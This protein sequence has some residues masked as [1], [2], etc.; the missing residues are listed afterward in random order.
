M[1]KCLSR[2]FATVICAGVMLST[3]LS[4]AA[5]SYTI[6]PDYP[7]HGNKCGTVVIK[8][9][10]DREITVTITQFTQDGDYVYYN[11][12]IPACGENTGLDDYHF[13]LEGKDDVSY[14]ISL[15]VAKFK[16]SSTYQTIA[17]EFNIPDTDNFVEEVVNGYITTFVITGNEEQEEP[18]MVIDT[19]PVTDENNN[20]CNLATVVYP[21]SEI[22]LGDLTYDE[23]VNIYDVIELAKYI[24]D[25][26]IFNEAQIQAGDYN[27]DGT[28]NLHDAIAIAKMIMGM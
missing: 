19:E 8:P 23:K 10:I 21:V 7:L 14:S 24:M 4:A 27:M 9:E 16:G 12:V 11:K 25:P 17:Y 5:E 22:M 1:K 15:G 28:T 26:T 2:I 20:I 18:E 13:R 3:S 6:E